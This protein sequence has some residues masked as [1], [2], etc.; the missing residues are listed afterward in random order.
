M[1]VKVRVILEAKDVQVRAAALVEISD[2]DLLNE[3]KIASA[4]RVL[5]DNIEK[6]TLFQPVKVLTDVP[7]AAEWK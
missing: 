7:F 2:D 1:S 3:T 5:A 6:G 4:L